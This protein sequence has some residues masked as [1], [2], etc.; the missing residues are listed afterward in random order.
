MNCPSC[1]NPFSQISSAGVP[2]LVCEGRCG[3]FWFSKKDLKKLHDRRIGDGRALLDIVTAEG[4]RLYRNV[5]H[6][7]PTCTITTLYRHF[8]SRQWEF[9]VDQCSRCGAFWI[10]P[11]LL[12]KICTEDE[13]IRLRRA[14]GYFKT[15]FTEKIYRMDLS[16]QDVQSSARNIANIF[17]FTLPEEF[18]ALIPSPALGPELNIGPGIRLGDLNFFVGI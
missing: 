4:V 16:K 3:G 11:G 12:R 18:I 10:D 17:L 2:G 13:R 14:E 6:V 15:V 5:D 8:F 7:C 1:N 9:E